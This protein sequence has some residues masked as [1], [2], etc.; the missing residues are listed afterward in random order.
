MFAVSVPHFF[1]CF[2]TFSVFLLYHSQTV[3]SSAEVLLYIS[4]PLVA[5]WDAEPR[6]DPALQQAYAL[7]TELC[8]TLTEIRRTLLSY[9]APFWA[10]PHPNWATSHPTELR[11][12][13]LSYAAPSLSSYAAPPL[14]FVCMAMKHDTN[15]KSKCLRGHC[16][17]CDR[18]IWLQIYSSERVFANFIMQKYLKKCKY[19]LWFDRSLLIKI[20]VVSEN[21]IRRVI[22]NAT[23][24]TFV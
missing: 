14:I 15:L 20:H 21:K 4:S 18:H 11:S 17:S 19:Y 6:F 8:S 22:A 13:L 12:T 2:F 10:K 24:R 5:Q 7:T 3:H 23:V 16:L 1:V 9:A